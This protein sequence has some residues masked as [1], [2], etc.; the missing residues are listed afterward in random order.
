[1]NRPSSRLIYVVA[2]LCAAMAIW[3]MIAPDDLASTAADITGTI[4]ASLDWFFM[5]SVT[6]FLG[7]TLWLGLGRYGRLRLGGPD[8]RPEFSTASWLSMLFSAGMG[9]GI[10]FWGVAEPMTHY[11]APP[12]GSGET[13]LA[14]RRAMVLTNLHWGLHAWSVY[15][16]G[17]LVLGYFAF[18]RGGR[19]LAGAPLR[20]VFRGRW[21]GP[22]ANLADGIAVVAIAFGVA[23]SLV[24]GVMQLQTGLNLAVG[25]SADSASVGFA[26]LVVLTIA[27]MLSAATSLDKGIQLLSN[28]NVALA[29][30]LLVFVLLA[31]PTGFLLRSAATALGDYLTALP[32]LS[33]SLYPYQDTGGWLE[34][35]TLTYFIWWIAWAPFVGIF[36]ARI[37]RGRTIREFVLGVTLTPTLLSILWFAVFG[38]TGLHAEMT[39]HPGFASVVAEDITLA[40]FTLYDT[41]PGS[42]VL[43]GVSLVLIFV[44]LVTS[45][46]SATFVLG[47]LSSAGSLDP[48]RRQKLGWG[49]GLALMAAGLLLSRSIDA[50]R[51]VVVLGAIPFTFI[52]ILQLVALLRVLP[53]DLAQEVDR[54][55]S[56]PPDDDPPAPPAQPTDT[57]DAEVT[58]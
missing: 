45:A 46:D 6:A 13:A 53:G 18:R 16:I 30:L 4:F 31:G 57:V 12:I 56:G 25:W 50:V 22:V 39:D 47:M 29:L 21:V 58:A 1:M 49:V 11:V 54:V 51:A 32:G 7:L 5:G 34:A 43:T 52:L 33:L 15:C 3:G 48:P 2:P 24:M 26:I 14:A 36:I 38:G 17:A 8:E 35:W 23:G 19:W 41:L 44:F 20:L 42:L 40:L 9:V 37:S 10:L 27:Y 55:A 28:A